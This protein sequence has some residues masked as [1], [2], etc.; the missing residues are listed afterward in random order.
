MVVKVANLSEI[1]EVDIDV[2]LFEIREV[3][4]VQLGLVG[5]WVSCTLSG[6][7]H[8]AAPTA[9][10]GQQLVCASLGA[11]QISFNGVKGHQQSYL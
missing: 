9:E 8:F 5:D 4:R 6:L 11:R 10:L 7:H 2:D 3:G 1:L